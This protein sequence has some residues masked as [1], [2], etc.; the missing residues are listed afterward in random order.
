MRK[1]SKIIL[2][3][4]VATC[5]LL[6]LGY[7]AI[8]NITLNIAGTASA[9]ADSGN[10][11]V[12][13]TDNI[14]VSDSAY[15]TATRTEDTSATISVSGLTSA[16]DKVTATYEISNDSTDL[17]SDLNVNVTNSNANYFS[18]SS[19]LADKSIKAGESTTVL[20]TVELLKT[21]IEENVSTQ[22][23]VT[24]NAIPVQ[25]GEEGSSGLTNDFSK[26]PL[27]KSLNEYGF[28]YDEAYSFVTELDGVECMF[29]FV[30]SEDETVV[31]YSNED[32]LFFIDSN[33]VVYEENTII[34]EKLDF[35]C[36]VLEDGYK[37]R[38]EKLNVFNL[39]E[40]F[41]E[42]KNQYI[43]ELNEY[44]FYYDVP[45]VLG[46]NDQSYAYILHE[47]STISLYENRIY[48]NK[49][50]GVTYNKN[51][52]LFDGSLD[53][54]VYKNGTILAYG[55]GEA[56]GI[57]PNYEVTK[58]IYITRNT[59]TSTYEYLDDFPDMKKD[60]DAYLVGEYAYV[61]ASENW[62]MGIITD[63]THLPEGYVFAGKELESYSPI[64]DE[65]NGVSVK[66]IASAFSDCINLKTAPKIPS[67]VE[68]MRGTFEGCISLTTVSAIPW[69]V[70]DMTNTF[71]GCVSLE[72]EIQ[73]DSDNITE[74][75]GC[76]EGVDMSKITLTGSA[77]NATK[78]KLGR[79]GLNYIDLPE[80]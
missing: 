28:F 63:G 77:S 34:I 15:V 7:A 35:Q 48:V 47:D 16:G 75:A 39:N 36:T 11:K 9:T 8:S 65:I 22:I 24:L 17:S 27:D 29:S 57:N 10:F 19:K 56:I 12:R 2:V 42:R 5:I 60:G 33:D 23:G 78:N 44:G 20:V 58:G 1:T 59:E 54:T 69:S 70:T 14:V 68:N 79:T 4:I 21:P 41:M 3:T 74:Y 50:S 40:S 72:G 53:M 71:K 26:V 62:Y 49:V 80:N 55:T 76:F 43:G 30:F 13:F 67:N 18:I 46:L 45:Y 51:K 32:V 52:I 6:G 66:N 73:I 37:L 64:L 61:Y 25:P 38:D 31:L